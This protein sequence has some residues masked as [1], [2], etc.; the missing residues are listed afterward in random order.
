MAR[1]HRVDFDELKARADFRAV[2]QHY[3][4]TLLGSGDQAKV[5]CPFHDDERPSCSVNLAKSL[6]HCFACQAKGN[7]L[8]FVHRM[9]TKDGATVSLRQAGM[10]LAELCGVSVPGSERRQEPR[11]AS[12][13]KETASF[14]VSRPKR[15]S[16]WLRAAENGLRE[17]DRAQAQ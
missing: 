6:F 3:G 9:E 7:V 16:A 12:T 11:R 2:L 14:T 17:R 8:D 1:Q 4:L 13:A 5:R 10:K 15:R